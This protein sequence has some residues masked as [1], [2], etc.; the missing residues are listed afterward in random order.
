A[1]GTTY[2]V[3]N[4]LGNDNNNGLSEGAPFKSINKVNSL[5]LGAGDRVLFKC[6]DSWRAQ[7]LV[8]T[9]S[10]T[11]A[12]PLQFGSYPAGCANK[13]LIS[14]AQPISGWAVHSGN[15]YV[16]DLSAGANAGKFPAGLNQLFQGAER[17]PFGR[18]PDLD[19]GDGGYQAIDGH[20]GNNITDNQLPAGNW[21]GAH[22]HIKGMRWYILNRVVTND[23][24]STLTLNA[25]PDCWSGNCTGWGYFLT[26]HLNTLNRPGE[27]F[28]DEATNRVYL[29]STSGTPS[30]IE[31]SVIID[32][33]DEGF[34]G[35]IILGRHL[36]EEINYVTIENLE[37]S[38]WFDNGVTTPR[39]LELIDNS[40]LTIRDLTVRDIDNAAIF[41]STW[42]WN[43]GANS[44]WRGGRDILVENNLIERANHTAINS[45]TT[46]STFR[47]NIVRDI[48][49]IENLGPDGMGCPFDQGGGFCTRDGMAFRF[50]VDKPAFSG[51]GNTIEYNRL[52]RTGSS[53][54]QLFGANNVV[55][56]NVIQESGFAKGDNGGISVYGSSNF[57]ST[58]AHDI[59][60][61]HNVVISATGNTDGALTAFRPLFGIGIYIDNWA[62]N[63]AVTDN[64]VVGATIDG[65]LF[66][67]ARGTITGNT[68]YNN[69]AGSMSRGQIGIYNSTSQI[70]SLSNNIL[71]GLNYLDAFTFAKTL[72]TEN[73]GAADITAANNNYYFNEYRADNISI[74]FNLQTLA[75]WQASSGLDGNSV[76]SWFTLN[77]GDPPRSRLFLNDTGTPMQIDLGNSLYLDLDQNPV[78]G[79]FS[80]APYSAR[81]LIDS[82]QLALAPAVLY[83]DDETSPAQ[84]VTLL[85]ITGG[86]LQISSIATTAHFSQS[87]NCPATLSTGA[88]CTIDVSF[89]PSQPGPQA[90][91]LTV[92]HDAGAPYTVQLYGGFN[93]LF[94][95]I[96]TR[97]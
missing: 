52:E 90:G 62:N 25:F 39:N 1:G 92:S 35:G 41:L 96:V 21:T 34:H 83:F 72:H 13:P 66:Q 47:G 2:Y 42:V 44:G 20:S 76:A 97:R 17:L 61:H 86:P 71:Y 59:T 50:P 36:M 24:G 73:A 94:L 46:N 10:G 18:W 33:A 22:A 31:G 15:I 28:Y 16:A 11:G 67:N 38:R 81:V 5:N 78:T 93:K 27:W 55:Q 48:A 58:N 75:Q 65:I 4:S 77:I 30:N 3:S 29:Y 7:S 53:G 45:Y 80:L 87:N 8:I 89:T 82:G 6:G 19:N 91:T 54:I 43:A 84:P 37:V 12:E 69:N 63:I 23:S 74:G 51:F 88:S 60:I 85:N 26:N 79:S 9:D 32:G 70:S 57:G 56:F 95:P 49:L 64:T 68:L 40:H 14:G